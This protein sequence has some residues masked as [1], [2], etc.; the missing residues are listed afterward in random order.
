M[1]SAPFPRELYL[2]GNYLECSGAL[3]LLRP[4]ADFAETQGKDQLTPGS[5]D[6]GHPPQ[7]LQGKCWGT[8]H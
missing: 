4:I 8:W 5:P 2:E 1:Y 3:A 6:A 7:Q